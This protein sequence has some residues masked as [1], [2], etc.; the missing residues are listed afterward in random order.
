MLTA[1]G[2]YSL[3]ALAHLATLEPGEVV[4][5]SE[6]AE[7]NN[8]PKKFLDAILGDL[9][10]AGLVSTRKGPGGGYKLARGPSEIKL[11]DVIRTVD[12]P[13]AP[14]AC[15]SRTAYQPCQDCKSVKSCN[16][17]LIMRRVRDAMS[18]VL[19]RVTISDMVAMN[20]GTNVMP[21]ALSAAAGRRGTRGKRVTTQRQR[22]AR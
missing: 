12:G 19:D 6:I 10:T 17:R 14:L 15:A 13:L 4:P 5:G 22:T 11:G 1:K 18:E 8:I 21:I 2:K 16:V 20:D 3:K 9:R 7:A